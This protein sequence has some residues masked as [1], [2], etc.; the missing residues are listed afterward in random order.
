M[1]TLDNLK[2]ICENK[3]V[4][5]ASELR[6]TTLKYCVAR[7]KSLE[8]VGT[9]LLGSPWLGTILRSGNSVRVYFWSIYFKA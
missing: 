3:K 1:S 4:L 2:S 8:R 6:L 7:Q 5:I 9:A